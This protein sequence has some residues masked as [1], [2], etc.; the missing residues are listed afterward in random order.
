MANYLLAEIP[1][2]PDSSLLFDKFAD[3]SWSVFLDSNQPEA[4][5]GR[6][7]IISARPKVKI[8]SKNNKNN[9][10]TWTES[11]S[12]PGDPFSI[13]SEMIWIFRI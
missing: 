5:H 7:D 8:T 13:L 2:S 10:D 3:E 6:Y 11:L 12:A 4:I 9:I 1:Y